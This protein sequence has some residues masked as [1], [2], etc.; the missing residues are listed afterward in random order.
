MIGDIPV[1]AFI[2]GFL[3]KCGPARHWQ[4]PV[5]FHGFPIPRFVRLEREDLHG[6]SVYW[7]AEVSSVPDVVEGVVEDIV[8]TVAG[9]VRVPN[10]RKKT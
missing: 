1:V 9:T 5:A 4:I 6:R 2:P 3:V 10:V 8:L 7:E